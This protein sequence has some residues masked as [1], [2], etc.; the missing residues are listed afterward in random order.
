MPRHL[1]KAL[2]LGTPLIVAVA[3]C[4][5]LLR[6]VGG[7]RAKAAADQQVITATSAPAEPLPSSAGAVASESPSAAPSVSPS[8][9]PSP[10]PTATKAPAAK[11]PF[12]GVANSECADL[13]RLTTSWFYNWATSPGSCTGHG[14]VPMVSGKNQKTATAVSDAI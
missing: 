14:F 13:D 8:V 9:T 3:A 4:L 7:E 6:P 11:Q 1:R 2:L 12:K 5:Y 10:S